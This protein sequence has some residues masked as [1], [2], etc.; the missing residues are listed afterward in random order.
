VSDQTSSKSGINPGAPAGSAS[1]GGLPDYLRKY[2]WWAYLR[3]ASIRFFDRNLVVSAILWGQYRKLVRTALSEVKPG[4]HVLQ[5]ACVYGDLSRH[6][7]E[8]LG[9]RGRLDIIDVAPI[10]VDNTRRKLAHM[11]WVTTRVMDAATPEKREYDVVLCFF[12]LHELPDFY[13]RAVVDG[14]LDHLRPNGRAVFI[15]YH[16]PARWHPLRPVQALVFALLEPF[17]ARLWRIR[18]SDLA[19]QP[20]RFRWHRETR[21]GGF[22]QKLVANPATDPEERKAHH[23]HFRNQPANRHPGADT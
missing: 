18:I 23:D 8:R 15:D 17:A 22:Y 20:H 12:L 7:A 19:R 21:F 3:P 11:P 6:I 4:D 5:M 14:A 2:Y 13:K 1:A 10:Q 9:P 16:R